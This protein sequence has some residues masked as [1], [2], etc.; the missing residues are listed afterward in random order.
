MKTISML[1]AASFLSA[2][3]LFPEEVRGQSE[4]AEAKRALLEKVRVMEA[5]LDK[6]TKGLAALKSELEEANGSGTGPSAS[7]EGPSPSEPKGSAI[8]AQELPGVSLGN[9]IRLIPYGT[10]Y[11]N[12]FANT[13]GTNNTDVPLWATANEDENLGMSLR[14]TRFGVRIEGARIGNAAVKGVVEADFYGGLPAVGVGENFGVVRLR[15]AKVRFEWEKAALTV[16]QDWIVFAPRNPTSIAAAAI[17]QFAA[18]GNLWS[19]LPQV[20]AE[21][22]FAGGKYLIEGAV[23]APTS[24]DF[25]SGP[26]SP[27]LLQPGAASR[28]LVPSF[29]GRA[30]YN[31]A[32]WLGAGKPGS[33]AVS[34]HFGRSKVAE[35][36]LATYGIAADWSFPLVR[37]V[38]FAGELYF[39]ENLGGLQGGIFQGYNPDSISPGNGEGETGTPRGINTWGGWAQI[40]FTPPMLSDRL[41]FHGSAGIDDPSDEDLYSA[42]PRNWRSRNL[43]YAASVIYKPIPRLSVGGEFRRFETSYSLT[44]RRTASHFNLGAAYEF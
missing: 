24:G 31:G 41:S 39:G 12:A 38:A 4:Q 32:N 9:G 11:F 44:G 23:L 37:R 7:A 15:V 14:Q 3:V 40:S 21:R 42:S 36:D 30:A 8:P 10:V 22:K 43:S 25:P 26:D 1:I 29:E 28:S 2:V 20:R 16:G 35:T 18:S 19:R 13:S 33:A 5:E 6:L 27:F 17:P 34:F